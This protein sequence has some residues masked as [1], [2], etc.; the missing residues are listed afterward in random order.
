MKFRS[1]LFRSPLA[2]GLLALTALLSAPA[3]PRAEIAP[4]ARAVV[5]RYLEATGGRAA[6]EAQRSQRVVATIS[7]FGLKGTARTW[8]ASPDRRA[9]EVV[10][11]PFRLLDGYDGVTAWRTDPSGKMLKLDGK[12]REDAVA[13]AWFEAERWCAADQGGGSVANAG[14]EKDLGDRHR[15]SVVPVREPGDLRP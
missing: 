5:E 14:S 3:A 7:A 9:S 6:W 1:A 11:G 8:S 13:G 15:W 10:L 12:D 2:A 4:E